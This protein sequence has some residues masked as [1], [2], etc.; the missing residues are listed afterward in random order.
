MTDLTGVSQ[1]EAGG[2]EWQPE[3]TTYL[4]MLD[5]SA[6]RP[7]STGRAGLEL[8]RVERAEFAIGRTLY[9]EVGADWLWIDRL[10]WTDTD[11]REYY[12]RPGI[13]LW[14]GSVVND[15]AGYFELS[16]DAEGSTEIAYFG[17]LPAFIGRGLGGALLT[18]AIERAWQN[19]ARR[20]WVHTSSRDHAHAFGNYLARG[21]RIYKTE[22]KPAPTRPET[23]I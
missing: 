5:P 7:A 17:L 18:A 19:G 23:G 15:R 13:E 21:F 2:K 1:G 12:Q 16:S 10:A 6:L 9:I 22:T 20:V 11:W 14:I 4:E 8:R 3:T